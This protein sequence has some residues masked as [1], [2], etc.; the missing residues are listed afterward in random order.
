MEEVANNGQ[1][2]LYLVCE[3]TNMPTKWV[4]RDVPTNGITTQEYNKAP[5]EY[6]NNEEDP[7]S[8]L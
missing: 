7:Q 3:K 5:S 4:W 8:I 1:N 2:N 6:K